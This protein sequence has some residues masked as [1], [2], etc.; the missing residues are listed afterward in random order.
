MEN[1]DR[2]KGSDN[3]VPRYRLSNVNV[4]VSQSGYHYTDYL[5]QVDEISPEIDESA[6]ND[7][8]KKCHTHP[9]CWEPQTTKTT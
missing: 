5:D 9:M 1:I 6:L 7:E 2:L 4:F 8:E 3:G